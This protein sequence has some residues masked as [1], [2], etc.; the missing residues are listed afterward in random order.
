MLE[1]MSIDNINSWISGGGFVG[2]IASLAYNTVWCK[3]KLK[4]QCKES[5]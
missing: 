2:V 1:T 5:R 4:S 3:M